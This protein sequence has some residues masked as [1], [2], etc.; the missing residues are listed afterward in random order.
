MGL[1][2]QLRVID[3][4]LAPLNPGYAQLIEAYSLTRVVNPEIGIRKTQLGDH[5]WG[6]YSRPLKTCPET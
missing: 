2:R 1:P 6:T 3:V 5:T 4:R